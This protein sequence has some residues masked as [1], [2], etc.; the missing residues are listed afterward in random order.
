MI[1]RDFPG[2]PSIKKHLPIKKLPANSG[3]AGLTPGK[4]PHAVGQLNPWATT[5]DPTRCSY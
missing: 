5:P 2:G 3:N 4:I 1:S